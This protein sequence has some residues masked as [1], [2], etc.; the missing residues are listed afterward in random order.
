MKLRPESRYGHVIL[1]NRCLVLAAVNIKDVRMVMVLLSY[2]CVG[3]RIDV[4]AVT[5][6]PIN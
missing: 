5:L 6:Q 1:V 4:R 3:V 2:F